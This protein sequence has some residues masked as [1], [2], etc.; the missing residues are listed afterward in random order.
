[1]NIGLIIAGGV[2]ARMKEKVPKQFLK[3][4]GKSV[5]FYTLEAFEKNNNIDAIVV[6]CVDGWQEELIR[7]AKAHGIHK[8]LKLPSNGVVPGGDT[9]M[10]SLR[11][12][13]MY[14]KE[15]FSEDSIVV[16]HDA[17]RPLISQDL[18]SANVAGVIRYG[19]AITTIPSTEALLQVTE[20]D[21]ETSSVV[22][23]R[24][25]I[26]RT[27]TPQSLRLSKFIWAH[28]EAQKRGIE[29]TV[30]T[31]TLLIELGEKVHLIL[32]ET[33]NFKLTTP[34]DIELMNAYLNMM[35]RKAN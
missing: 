22:V 6:V 3:V 19:N 25:Y 27:Q 5:V 26:M 13:M 21:L 20:D 17:V 4:K 33:I 14:L 11:N 24:R 8:M 32:G 35:D 28:E 12:G 31:C 23:D 7:G 16:I 18:I 30:A 10:H 34:E 29:D 2:G 9:G 1:M 15:N